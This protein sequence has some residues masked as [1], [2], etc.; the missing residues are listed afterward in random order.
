VTRAD[1]HTVRLWDAADPAAPAV[2][3]AHAGRVSHVALDPRGDVLAAGDEAG[4]ALWDVP[5][6]RPRLPRCAHPA[7]VLWVAFH[8][9]GSSLATAGADGKVRFGSATT[10]A[11]SGPA[12]D[13]GAPASFV[14][15]DPAGRRVLVA[16]EADRA[17]V[18]DAATGV[19]V[20]PPVPHVRRHP[21]IRGEQ[22]GSSVEPRFSPDGATFAG[23]W[24]GPYVRE[25]VGG[26]VVSQIDYDEKAVR[27]I[28]FSPDGQRVL[29]H[30]KSLARW[31]KPGAE[32]LARERMVHP[33]ESWLGAISPDGSRVATAST[34]GKVHL[35][36]P[37]AGQEVVPP[38][39]HAG[40]IRAIAFSPDG[41][42]VAAGGTDGTVRVWE[43]AHALAPS[44]VPAD[45]HDSFPVA[46]YSADRT[47]TRR[48][49]RDGRW[50]L[51]HRPADRT[52]TLVRRETGQAVF[53]T[54]A[55][56]KMQASGFTPDGRV[57]YVAS[58]GAVQLWDAERGVC[59]V[60]RIPLRGPLVSVAA[61]PAAG[62]ALVIDSVQFQVYD[63][64][65][66][67]C[68]FG[69]VAQAANDPAAWGPADT[70]GYGVSRGDISPDGKRVVVPGG[71]YRV[72]RSYDLGSGRSV[73]VPLHDGLVYRA[74]FDGSGARVL[75]CGSDSTA[76]LWEP[77]TGA[78]LGPA[79]WHPS[80]VRDAALSAD[81]RTAVT[82]A[83]GAV[84]LW[85]A[86]TG[87]LLLPPLPHPA[88]PSFAR[89]YLSADGRRVVSQ[90]SDD[91]GARVIRWAVPEFAA[92][93]E[94]VPALV[95]L[96]TGREV[97]ATRGLSPI[98]DED[99]RRDRDRYQS[100][101]RSFHATRGT[102][103]PLP[104]STTHRQVAPPPR[105]VR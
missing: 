91:K 44:A 49:S 13:V 73:D 84:R 102:L 38:L 63:L 37:R 62:R 21:R 24:T 94:S 56:D 33:R 66:G 74:M 70:T 75:T 86:E 104:D 64:A 105:S 90:Y 55:P 54:S 32:P 31:W 71:S 78:P 72:L 10:G 34:A 85:D 98:R 100:S 11:A 43:P 15:F 47:A 18:Y 48:L 99:L 16:T 60:D 46:F 92:P 30:S 79:L 28:E 23:A 95:G 89:L 36:D 19:A 57:I 9:A 65:T 29:V 53:T 25:V 103:P 58:E 51:D 81:G 35:W 88:R 87:D 77:A 76:R 52:L 3:M 6:G 69:P 12:I 101:F 7:P 93:F 17:A 50:R 40:E 20:C 41:S 8:P 42:C 2:E 14:A 59:A 45:D 67:R 97:D 80:F 39:Q 4:C 22:F 26:K 1:D 5:S 96:F 27:H 83:E 82:Y 68:V 61:A